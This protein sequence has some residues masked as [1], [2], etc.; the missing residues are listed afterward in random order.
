MNNNVVL[1]HNHIP[2]VRSEIKIE[3]RVM[4][5]PVEASELYQSNLRSIKQC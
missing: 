4:L 3:G 1:Q 5:C 2:S